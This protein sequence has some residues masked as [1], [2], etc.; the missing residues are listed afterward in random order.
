[1]GY[2]ATLSLCLFFVTLAIALSVFIWS[3]K[4]VYYES[5]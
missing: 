4:W 3:K 2:A 5:E 1:M